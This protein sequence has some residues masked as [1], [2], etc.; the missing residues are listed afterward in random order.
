MT[1]EIWYEAD[2]TRLFAVEDGTGPPIILLH[3]GLASHLAVVPLVAPLVPRFRVVLPDVRGNGRSRYAGPLS[4]DLLADDVSTLVRHLGLARAVIG[5]ASSGS[6]AAVR[7]A[8]RMP[9]LLAGLVLVWPI[10]GGAATGLAATQATTFQAMDALGSRAVVEGVQVLRPLYDGLPA[11]IREG[12][13]RMLEG[14]D[15]AS[16]ATTTRFLAAG[17]QPFAAPDDLQAITAPTLVVPGAD[18]LHPPEVA[19]LYARHV[20]GCRVR[21]GADVAGAI[22]QFC[23][24]LTS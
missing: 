18:A 6:G 8:L 2:G 17:T 9:E 20:P 4:W 1:R 3:G 16:V 22:T 13:L 19:A 21:E 5:G 24:E 11:P 12:A 10:Y 14:F 15:P 7:L 23:G